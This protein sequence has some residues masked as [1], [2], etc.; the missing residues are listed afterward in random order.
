MRI[1]DCLLDST[2]HGNFELSRATEVF[3]RDDSWASGLVYIEVGHKRTAVTDDH[4]VHTTAGY[5]PAR[6]L[7]V[8]SA[9]TDNETVTGIWRKE[10]DAN[11]SLIYTKSGR[12]VADGIVVSSYG[13]WTDP[14]LSFDSYVLYSLRA[15]RVLESRWYKAYFRMESALMDPVVHWLWPMR[16]SLRK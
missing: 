16:R 14:W 9:L 5:V 12:F 11:V 8:G 1:G 15:T 3:F 13:H 7:T 6:L 10:S 4:L 2:G